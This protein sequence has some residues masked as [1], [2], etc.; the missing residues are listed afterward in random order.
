[1]KFTKHFSIY[2]KSKTVNDLV[3]V[4]ADVT[5]EDEKESNLLRITQI[6]NLKVED[7]IALS[8][9]ELEL[10]KKSVLDDYVS[11]N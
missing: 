6:D 5:I 2:V 3:L 11:S 1:M 4:D 7:S 8:E 10:F 9:P